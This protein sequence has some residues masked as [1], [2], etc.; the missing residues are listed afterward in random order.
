[1]N[2]HKVELIIAHMQDGL[3]VREG[4]KVNA[5][6]LIG[7]SGNSGN[8][9]GKNGGYHMHL[10]VKVDGQY[11]DPTKARKI[12]RGYLILGRRKFL[13]RRGFIG[14]QNSCKRKIFLRLSLVR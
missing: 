14:V 7:L 5:G 1:M 6:D 9:R 12:L 11:V 8:S 2:G 3:N 4:D 10:E 13:T